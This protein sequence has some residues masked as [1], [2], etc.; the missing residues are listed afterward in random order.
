MKNS[1]N[2]FTNYFSPEKC[3]A[4]NRMNNLANALIERN[5][6]I[7]I[8]TSM[9]NYPYGKVFKEYRKRI[10]KYENMNNLNIYRLWIY[11][12]NSK[13]IFIRLFSM[14][15]F[16]L[17]LFFFLPK[18]FFLKGKY[19]LIQGH[20]LIS[21]FVSIIICK[22]ILRRKVILNISDIWPLSGL[23]LGYFK[24]NYMYK[25]LKFIEKMNYNLSDKIIV[26]SEETKIYLN[27]K[28]DKESFLYMNLPNHSFKK[29]IVDKYDNNSIKIFYAGLLGHAQ[30]IA[31]LCRTINFDSLDIEFHIFGD[32]GEA[33]EIKKISNKTN[34]II[35]HGMTDQKDL[36]K[37]II[38]FDYGLVAL[39]SKI[40]GAFPSKIYDLIN[41]SIPILYVGEGAP[42][43]MIKKYNIGWTINSNDYVKLN[44]IFKEIKNLSKEEYLKIVEKMNNLSDNKYCFNK[45]IIDFENFCNEL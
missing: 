31:K 42:G 18:L 5:Y 24:K 3:A 44:K 29:N 30:G 9:P 8:I 2:I 22:K 28:F 19:N 14:F 32:G 16:S 11:P 17:S 37:K 10:Y 33:K 38:D 41:L 45:Q 23:E 21:T 12:S 34:N 13:N 26:Q 39:A 36:L 7:N 40:Y 1:I 4:A 35:F 43:D 15:S 25:I 6:K 20:P 27:D